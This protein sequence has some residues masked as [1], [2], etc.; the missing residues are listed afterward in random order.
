ML[1]VAAG[2]TIAGCGGSGH[3]E[4]RPQPV[5]RAAGPLGRITIDA[6][7]TPDTPGTPS[8]PR[9]V[10]LDIALTI[11]GSAGV[12]AP[13]VHSVVVDLPGGTRYGGAA[14]PGCALATLRRQG[15]AGCPAASI[16]GHGRGVAR[17][18]TS[19]SPV[20]LT[21]INGG[22]RHAY[23]WTA[24]DNPARV[25]AVI[26]GIVTPA[27]AGGYRLALTIPMSLQIVAGVPVALQRLRLQAQAGGWLAT[28][29]CSGG[30]WRYRARV[31]FVDGE[32]AAAAARVPCG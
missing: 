8:R 16:V 11:S 2:T 23:I 25:R 19:P 17:V 21:V 5:T 3:Q 14:V 22:S 26:D 29:G 4:H 9:P 27:A 6:G 18:D 15:P 32:H 31:T 24:M 7:V 28:T 20:A 10:R 12:D 13:L 1:A 30:Q